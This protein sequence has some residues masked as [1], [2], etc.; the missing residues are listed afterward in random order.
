MLI[1]VAIVNYLNDT[2]SYEGYQIGHSVGTDLRIIIDTD[3]GKFGGYDRLAMG[4][5]NS[6]PNLEPFN[7]RLA[8]IKLYLPAR[9]CL[10]RRTKLESEPGF[11]EIY[12]LRKCVNLI[13]RNQIMA[14]TAVIAS[15]RADPLLNMTADE[16]IS[17][18][19][20]NA[21]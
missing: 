11:F 7:K 13:F 9:T 12:V 8:S 17:N 6:F 4:H 10:V 15:T 20:A 18:F 3:E 21:I 5:H 19:P 16:F 2:Q 1:T 14:P